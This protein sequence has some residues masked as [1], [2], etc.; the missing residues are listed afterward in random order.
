MPAV[1]ATRTALV[2]G[3]NQGMGRQVARELAADGVAV[4]VGSRD[5]ARGRE[6]A[7]G[8][9]GGAT[10]LQLDVT[11][12][13][14]IAA[15]AARIGEEAGRL[16]LLVNNAG[17]ST[18]RTGLD[19][20]AF[21]ATSRP[22]TAPLD[23]VRAVW[24]VNVFGVLAL[25]QAVLPLLRRSPD[26]RIVNV[27]SA[28]GSLTTVADPAFPLRSAFEP[29]Y[30][31]SKTAL[32]AVTLAMALELEGTGIK[33]NLVSPGFARTALTN[34]EGTDSVEDA[35]RE[36]VRVARLGPDGPTGTFTTWEGVP[37]PW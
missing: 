13:V 1:P 10:A 33:V 4:Y 15:A 24:G 17:I 36:V 8:I 29:V 22:S 27:T 20:A 5:L 37:V 26:A 6:A 12:A 21:R 19:V 30:G 14:S 7:A 18:T 28:L 34:F 31:A 23:D 2:T 3:A 16:D 9:G 11:D 25:Y 35:A 32:N